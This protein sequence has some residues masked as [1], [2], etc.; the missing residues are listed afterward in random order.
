[1]REVKS[2]GSFLS[3]S[4]LRQHFGLGSATTIDEVKIRWPSGRMQVERGVPV[5][6]ITT[7]T[8]K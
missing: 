1:M 7:I 4:D 8:E 6:R 3:Q 2:G 5:N